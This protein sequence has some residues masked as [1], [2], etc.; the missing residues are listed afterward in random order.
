MKRRILGA[1][2]VCFALW[3]LVQHALVRAYGV[4]PWKL[5]GWAMYCIPGPMKTVRVVL[6][7]ADGG[8]RRLDLLRYTQEEQALVDRFRERRRALGRLASAES[9]AGEMLALHPEA[10]GVFVPVLS[11]VL[12]PD[13][14]LLTPRFDSSTHWRD[15][16]DEA[17]RF[18][19]PTLLGF[20]G[21]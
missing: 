20:F 9:L 21:P 10:A 19:D 7:D 16:R 4:D 2:L 18:D 6:V 17:L 11:F 15:E 1:F 8:L 5:F 3:P 13:T 12:D 14:A